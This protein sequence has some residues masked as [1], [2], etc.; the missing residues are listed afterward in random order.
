MLN[1]WQEFL[2][3]T[4]TVDYKVEKKSDTSYLGRFTFDTIMDFE[5]LARV[6]MIIARGYLFHDADGGVLDGDPWERT[7]YARRALCA[8]CSVPEKG[9]ATPKEAWQFGTDFRDLHEEF[10]ALV[11]RRGRGW[12]CRHVHAVAQLIKENPGK[13][14]KGVPEKATAI[15]KGFDKEWRKKVVQF[16]IPIFS[17]NTKGAWIIRFDD[18]IADALELGPLRQSQ[19]EFSED[20]LA[21]IDAVMPYGVP[22]HIVTTLI[23]YYAV[24]RRTDTDWV[25]LPVANFDAYFGSTM[26]SRKHM[27][28]LPK[29]IIERGEHGFGISRYRVP[30]EY[31]P[32]VS[33]P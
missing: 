13:M 15:K 17:E 21:R 25:V 1:E 3:Y 33:V 6:L 9:T 28:K 5:G 19:V 26:F 30:E 23:A 14:R 7:A 32:H 29:E 11:D 24:N 20:L 4:G 27:G 18:V 31:L 22:Q 10:P 12:F 2:D 8:W 16:Q